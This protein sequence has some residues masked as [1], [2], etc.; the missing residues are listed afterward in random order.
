MCFSIGLI[1]VTR[2]LASDGGEAM[3]LTQ[4][5]GAG[6]QPWAVVETIGPFVSTGNQ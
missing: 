3:I 1:L 6:H 2:P 4:A 5:G